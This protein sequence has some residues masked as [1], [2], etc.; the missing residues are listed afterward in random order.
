MFQSK[1]PA[2]V[3][4]T[5]RARSRLWLQNTSCPDSETSG[6]GDDRVKGLEWRLNSSLR[7]TWANYRGKN[8]NPQNLH[9]NS[10]WCTN[11]TDSETSRPNAVHHYGAA[12]Y[13]NGVRKTI[14]KTVKTAQQLEWCGWEMGRL[15]WTE[16]VWLVKKMRRYAHLTHLK[17][18]WCSL[19]DQFSSLHSSYDLQT[20]EQRRSGDT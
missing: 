8:K 20:G 11:T 10:M 1:R 14:R 3:T 16:I 4:L 12:E 7:G 13:E 9:I 2:T 17:H 5:W 19:T 18:P 6:M 15:T